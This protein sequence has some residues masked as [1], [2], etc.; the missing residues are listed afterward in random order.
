V[1]GPGLTRRTINGSP[2]EAFASMGAYVFG[3]AMLAEALRK[4]AG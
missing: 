2:D 3:T 4:D 1:T